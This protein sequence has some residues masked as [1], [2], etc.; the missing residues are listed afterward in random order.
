MRRVILAFLALSVLALPCLAQEGDHSL[1]TAGNSPCERNKDDMP[2]MDMSGLTSPLPLPHSGSGTD[3][4]PASVPASVDDFARPMGSDG[5][6]CRFSDLQPAR[7]P[8]W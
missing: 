2:G 7:W 5:A 4:Q 8:A 6:W 1:D 3:W